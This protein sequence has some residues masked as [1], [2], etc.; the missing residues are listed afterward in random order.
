METKK[1]KKTD[2]KF[3]CAL[4]DYKTSDKHDFNRHLSTR[5][6]LTRPTTTG[7]SEVYKLLNDITS[8]NN[9]KINN[10][11]ETD[12]NA[13]NHMCIYCNKKYK[14]RSGLWKHKKNCSRLVYDDKVI[15]GNPILISKIINLVNENK[16]CKE[17]NNRIL[18]Q[19]K[20]MQNILS[21]LA[22]KDNIVTTINNCNNITN[23]NRFNINVFLNE[24][25]KDAINMSE[26]LD[27]LKIDFEDLEYVGKNGYVEGITNIFMKN[28]NELDVYKRPIHCTDKKREVFYIKDENIW[29]KDSEEN[30]KIKKIVGKV[31]HKNLCMVSPWQHAHPECQIL[32]STTYNL[33]MNIMKQ[34]LNG[35]SEENSKKNDEKIINNLS[36]L[37]YV[38]KI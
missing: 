3:L 27:S 36:K 12:G 7:I 9:R 1:L 38:N 11:L 25:C 5:K 19:N 16:E 31:A 20:E 24:K 8:E 14:N 21:D 35:G 17:L 30:T 37:V 6:H 33:H 2:Y 18:E 34:S 29:E 23:N 4:C 10:I 32:D 13:N 28:L 26:F 15:E 22:K